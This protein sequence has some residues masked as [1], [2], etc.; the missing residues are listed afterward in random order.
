M[1]IFSRVLLM[2]L[3]LPTMAAWA[4]SWRPAYDL[5]GSR[6]DIDEQSIEKSASL[7]RWRER[8][9]MLPPVDDPSSLRR[10]REIQWRKQADCGKRQLKIL[11]HA[12]FSDD[13]AL[14]GYE[15]VRPDRVV[16]T[17][18]SRLA[19]VERKSVEALCGRPKSGRHLSEPAGDRPAVPVAGQDLVPV[20]PR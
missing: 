1:H 9:V 19:A 20:V 3:L 14:V 11:S 7:V 4:E 17:P 2:V 18:F 5:K 8:Q 13:D 15:G 12:A 10:V 16:G 6:V